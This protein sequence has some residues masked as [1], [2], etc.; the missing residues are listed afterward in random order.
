MLI[1][2]F[3]ARCTNH[4]S[5]YKQKGVDMQNQMQTIVGKTGRMEIKGS[6]GLLSKWPT[7]GQ[8]AGLSVNAAST[9][10]SSHPQTRYWEP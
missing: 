2:D 5:K 10:A 1:S 9:A 4:S 7:S 3:I 8:E 6:C